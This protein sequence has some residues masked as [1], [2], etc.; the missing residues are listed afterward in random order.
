MGDT[1]VEECGAC[2]SSY[3]CM[4]GYF[5]CP[6]QNQ[7]IPGDAADC[8]C[9]GGSSTK[10]GVISD[11]NERVESGAEDCGGEL[12]EFC[13]A[14]APEEDTYQADEE[15]ET[16]ILG[17]VPECTADSPGWPDHRTLFIP[18]TYLDT[19]LV[20]DAFITLWADKL[21]CI[22]TY[23][24]VSMTFSTPYLESYDGTVFDYVDAL[25]FETTVNAAMDEIC[26]MS[27]GSEEC[28]DQDIMVCMANAETEY[29][30][31]DGPPDSEESEPEQS[32]ES[33]PE[34]S[35]ES[36]PEPEQ[37]EESEPQPDQSGTGQ[38]VQTHGSSANALSSGMAC[39]M[40]ALLS[41]CQL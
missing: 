4:S 20:E 7:C 16:I 39:L 19:N 5:C 29:L 8:L 31:P 25:D 33:E 2:D 9:Y 38:A 32:E 24:E 28:A 23:I 21:C 37:S 1:G 27:M 10:S 3:E 34:Q 6:Y 13:P 30:L 17:Y 12:C 18:H 36:E 15:Q 41:I 26:A 40:V 14:T 35:E 11:N 22:Y